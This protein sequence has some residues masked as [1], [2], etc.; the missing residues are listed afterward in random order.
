[1]LL[2]NLYIS[3]VNRNVSWSVLVLNYF[4]SNIFRSLQLCSTLK[5]LFIETVDHQRDLMALAISLLASGS[6]FEDTLINQQFEDAVLD[7]CVNYENLLRTVCLLSKIVKPRP[8]ALD[9][10]LYIARQISSIVECCREGVAKHSRLF[11]RLGT[12]HSTDLLFDE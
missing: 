9:F 10:S 4:F 1:M 11:P 6:E 3:I 8:N 12:Q 2:F 5:V 7:L